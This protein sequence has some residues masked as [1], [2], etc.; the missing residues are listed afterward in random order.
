MPSVISHIQYIVNLPKYFHPFLHHQLCISL[1][2]QVRECRR[3][4]SDAT[5]SPITAVISLWAK[6][7]VLHKPQFLYSLLSISLQEALGRLSSCK[8][9]VWTT[10]EP[11]PQHCCFP[12]RWKNVCNSKC[13]VSISPMSGHTPSVTVCSEVERSILMFAEMTRGSNHISRKGM[14]S[15]S[16]KK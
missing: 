6:H 16:T 10:C 12:S 1:Q 15:S 9:A 2:T 3:S 5:S 11:L 4:T 13:H 8:W 7:L 14:Y